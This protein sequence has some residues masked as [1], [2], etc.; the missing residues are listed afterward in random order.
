MRCA[1]YA[2]Y[3]QIQRCFFILIFVGLLFGCSPRLIKMD[4]VELENVKGQD[5]LAIHYDPSPFVVRK[6]GTHMAHLTVLIGAGFGLGF[7]N[8]DDAVLYGS[9]FPI[10]FVTSNIVEAFDKAAGNKMISEYFL[11]DPTLMVKER[12][13]SSLET[14]LALGSIHHKK[15]AVKKDSLKS[16]NEIFG[17][18]VVIDFRTLTWGLTFYPWDPTHYYLTYSL[19]SRLVQLENKKILWQG[20]C[21]YRGY[22]S[23]PRPTMAQLK[24]NNGELLKGKLEQAVIE[25]SEQL[26]NQFSQQRRQ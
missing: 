22:D 25:C 2:S 5:I 13:I 3:S 7:S 21:R 16:L 23:K 26:A 1:I 11:D 20:V 24:A 4:L 9:T 19:R 17:N 12:F 10:V 8:V 18:G 14:D 6:F 15:E